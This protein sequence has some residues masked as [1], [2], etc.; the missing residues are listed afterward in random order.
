MSETS[1]TRTVRKEDVERNTVGYTIEIPYVQVQ[2]ESTE[3]GL[4]TIKLP[5]EAK[6][7]VTEIHRTAN[8]ELFIRHSIAAERSLHDLGITPKAIKCENTINK[9]LVLMKRNYGHH[10]CLIVVRATN[11]PTPGTAC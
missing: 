1:V 5:N 8:K 9:C 6:I 10:C 3:R 2:E 11:I 4:I 7:N